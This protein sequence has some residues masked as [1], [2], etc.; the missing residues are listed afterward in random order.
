M[1][2]Q[3]FEVKC[4]T[5]LEVYVFDVDPEGYE[6]WRTGQIKYVQDAFP[7]LTPDQRELMISR[8]CGPCFDRMFPEDADE[9]TDENWLS[10]ADG[11][12][13]LFQKLGPPPKE[14]K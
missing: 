11:L 14:G 7:Y 8:T 1:D 5:C 10:I 3:P 9:I 2:K 4:L 13:K 12:D 6:L